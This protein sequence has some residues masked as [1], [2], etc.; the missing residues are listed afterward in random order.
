M[1]ALTLRMRS[2]DAQ[3]IIYSGAAYITRSVMATLFHNVSEQRIDKRRCTSCRQADQQADH[4][5]DDNDGE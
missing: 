4:N 2:A 5:D 1:V 3:W